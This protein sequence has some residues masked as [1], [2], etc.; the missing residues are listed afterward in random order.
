MS[1]VLS[2]ASELFQRACFVTVSVNMLILVGTVVIW[3]YFHILSSAVP[4][5]LNSRV[6]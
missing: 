1:D 3:E 4:M 2:D 6:I 5:C